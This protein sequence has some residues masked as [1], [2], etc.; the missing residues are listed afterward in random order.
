MQLPLWMEFTLHSFLLFLRDLVSFFRKRW[1][2]STRRL[3]YVLAL[4]RSRSS[5]R[6]QKKRDETSQSIEPWSE[7]SSST[8]VICASRLPPSL[9]LIAGGDTPVIASPTPVSIEVRQPTILNPEDT[10]DEF[11]EGGSTEN[12]DIDGYSLAEARLISRSPNF[13]THHD[14]PDPTI[15]KELTSNS[16]TTPSRP[17]SQYSYRPA[18]QCA[19][20][21]SVCRPE[22]QYSHHM[23]SK[24]SYCSSPNLSGAES[25]ARGYLSERPSQGPPSP[26]LSARAPSVTDFVTSLAYRASRPVTS[27]RRPPPEL[28]RPEFQTTGF[29]HRDHNG[30]AA[31]FDPSL[32]PPP[33]GKLRPTIGIDRYEKHKMVTV[34]NVV[35]RRVCPPVTTQFLR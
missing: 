32:S 24:H 28:P 25:A 29:V 19:G 17:P 10:L 4:L 7:K 16:P 31:S 9:L 27:V 13:A 22:P 8:T 3:L 21:R 2:R 6:R 18:S 33:K 23:S 30:S 5:F 12:R 35:K 20:Y 34:E 15:P 11:Y 1:D 26:A 14:G